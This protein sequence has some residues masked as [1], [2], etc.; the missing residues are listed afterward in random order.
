MGKT[1]EEIKMFDE[2]S[3]TYTFTEDATEMFGKL[4]GDL[5]PQHMDEQYAADSI[6][7]RRVVHGMF[8]GSMFSKIFG[9]DYPGVGS[10]Y[11]KQ[12]LKFKKPV[13]FG[14]TIEA[15]VIVKEI[16]V[17][18]NRVIFNCISTNQHQEVVIEGEAEI[19]PPKKR[20]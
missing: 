18:R 12:S 14:D 6:F 3:Y 15:K 7:G 11:I 16:N 10:I 1:I 13:F 2:S 5:N 20:G 19:M 4:T 17:E 9:L 8:V